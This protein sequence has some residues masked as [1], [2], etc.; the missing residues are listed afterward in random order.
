MKKNLIYIVSVVAMLF[1]TSCEKVID[2][3][4]D[5]ADQQLVVEGILNDD[6][7]PAIVYITRTVGLN[8]TNNF[9]TVDNADVKLT[10]DAGN[11]Y[12]FTLIKPGVYLSDSITTVSLRRYTLTI[13]ADG[14]TYT[15]QAQMPSLVSYDSL[16]IDSLGFFGNSS[17]QLIPY[18]PDPVNVK[19][20]YRYKIYVNDEADKALYVTNDDFSDGRYA[21]RPYFSD[22]EMEPGDTLTMEMY[23]IDEA[24]YLYF[25]SL[26]QSVSG[27]D[28][29]ATPANPISNFN[30]GCLGYFSA[31]TKRSNTVIIP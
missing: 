30:G 8:A 24:I 7:G 13:N 2:I 4:V 11:S 28:Q 14:R 19:N 21:S 12:A 23:N 15:A 16:G 1:F 20:F 22:V 29:S 10:D 18:H 25:F 27:Q 5:D 3:D 9:P 17:Y 6:G 26:S 31:Q